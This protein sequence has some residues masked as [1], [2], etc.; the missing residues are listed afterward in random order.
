MM[1]GMK[2]KG[3]GFVLWGYKYWYHQAG[4]RKWFCIGDLL[5]SYTV[6]IASKQRTSGEFGNILGAIGRKYW[7]LRWSQIPILIT[8]FYFHL[9]G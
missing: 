3:N 4:W 9:V 8:T 6:S 5:K 1:R 2:W 7:V